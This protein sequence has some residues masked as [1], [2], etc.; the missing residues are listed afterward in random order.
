[1][2]SFNPSIQTTRFVGDET[3]DEKTYQVVEI[4]GDKPYHF[5]LKCYVG[6][7]KLVTRTS[8]QLKL[9]AQ[10]LTFGTV[11]KN[12]KLNTE[13]PDS[14]FAYTPPTDAV[15]YDPSEA[16]RHTKD[17]L[18]VGNKAPRFSARTPSGNELTLDSSLKGKKGV[19][20]SFWYH[21]CVPC[22]KEF[23]LLQKL[24]DEFK[25]KGLEIVAMNET[26]SAETVSRFITDSKLTFLFGLTT[27]NEGTAV[28]VS[29]KYG[30]ISCPTNYLLDA[31]GKV[32]WRGIGFE[33]D[34]IR[35]NSRNLVS[36]RG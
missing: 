18:A 2:G 33:E 30:V 10:T 20:I 36:N 7:D 5:V 34:Q 35:A 29:K 24:Y 4:T 3:F 21:S 1:M 12:V 19:L 17:L 23:P 25:G 14:D 9:G 27:P 28:G 26:D 16:A 32:I 8:L 11:L 6:K 22:R 31:E 13:M 15:F